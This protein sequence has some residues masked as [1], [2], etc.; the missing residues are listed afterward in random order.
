MELQVTPSFMIT[1]WHWERILHPKTS[2]SSLVLPQAFIL[3][4]MLASCKFY[5]A[6]LQFELAATDT[7]SISTRTRSVDHIF[8][9]VIDCYT[10]HDILSDDDTPP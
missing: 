8:I 10:T 4:C 3:V 7:A 9:S 6:Q 2:L 5:G 1:G